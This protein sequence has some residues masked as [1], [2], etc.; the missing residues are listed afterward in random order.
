MIDLTQTR[1]LNTQFPSNGA[2]EDSSTQ[3]VGNWTVF[4]FSGEWKTLCLVL[5]FVGNAQT[6]TASGFLPDVLFPLDLFFYPNMS[7]HI[8]I[9]WISSDYFHFFNVSVCCFKPG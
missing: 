7:D 5:P 9:L 4:Y 2:F 6:S 1:C 8:G 3:T